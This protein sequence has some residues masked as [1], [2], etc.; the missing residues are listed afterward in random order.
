MV[1]AMV[2]GCEK[3]GVRLVA[4]RS[5]AASGSPRSVGRGFCRLQQVTSLPEKDQKAVFGLIN[6]LVSI[7]GNH[8]LRAT[9]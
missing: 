8:R 6:S 9:G 3:L 2:G 7:S 1:A 4:P 5:W